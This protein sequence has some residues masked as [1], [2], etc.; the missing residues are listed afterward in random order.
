MEQWNSFQEP[1]LPSKWSVI[2]ER[3]HQLSDLDILP[4]LM[5]SGKDLGNQRNFWINDTVG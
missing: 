5:V 3:S 4:F 2:S 1:M